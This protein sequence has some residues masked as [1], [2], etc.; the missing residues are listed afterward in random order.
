MLQRGAEL[1]VS[2]S[3]FHPS[4]QPSDLALLR[5]GEELQELF[6]DDRTW[7]DAGLDAT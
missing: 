1:R 6:G 5:G 2:A 7:V 4:F 3:A